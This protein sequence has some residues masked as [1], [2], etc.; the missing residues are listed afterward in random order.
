MSFSHYFII[1]L[2]LVI[3]TGYLRFIQ[4]RLRMWFELYLFIFAPLVLISIFFLVI[5]LLFANQLVLI[6]V[7][8]FLLIF[9]SLGFVLGYG[10]RMIMTR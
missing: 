5:G 1:F 4:L 3:F 6:E 7:G 9:S 10:W 2:V 8:R